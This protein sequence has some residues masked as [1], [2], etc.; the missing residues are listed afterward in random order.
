MS[1]SGHGGVGSVGQS[2]SKT[3]GLLTGKPGLNE[4]EASSR[5]V[6]KGEVKSIEIDHRA[7]IGLVAF[8]ANGDYIVS[9]DGNKMLQSFFLI[10]PF[11]F[12][13]ILIV[14]LLGE[15]D[16]ITPILLFF[17][18]APYLPFASLTFLWT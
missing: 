17:S 9:G 12:S 15:V 7:D 13:L 16:I 18:F 2:Q 1:C 11:Y 4:N 6:E 5:I 14:Y 3:I 10:V 8:V